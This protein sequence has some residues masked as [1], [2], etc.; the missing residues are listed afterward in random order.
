MQEFVGSH[1]STVETNFYGQGKE[2][3]TN[4]NKTTPAFNPMQ[5]IHTYSLEW[6]PTFIAWSIDGQLVRVA[7]AA[8]A[9]ETYPQTPCYIKIGTWIGGGSTNSEETTKWA[10]GKVIWGDAPFKAWF[11]S[12]KV[13]DYGGGYSGA[14]EYTYGDQ[15]GSWNSIKVKGGIK[16]DMP[17]SPSGNVF[18]EL[19]SSSA[20]A[21]TSTSS[22]S[23]STSSTTSTSSTKS[24]M[25][26]PAPTTSNTTD[27]SAPKDTSKSN[28][29]STPSVT[30][31]AI[32]LAFTLLVALFSM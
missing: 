20:P 28:A 1:Q 19:T 29:G 23:S 15:S 22:S 30:S 13:Q 6:T 16:E 2:I 25:T 32:P 9:G 11:K 18:I 4:G 12:V 7:E 10:G 17:N 3:Y 14:A 8:K 31:L 24:T 5:S 26:T 21:P 27:S